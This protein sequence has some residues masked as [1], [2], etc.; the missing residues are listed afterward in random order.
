MESREFY[1]SLSSIGNGISWSLNNDN[2]LTGVGRLGVN[3]GVALNPITALATKRGLGSFGSNKRDT[4]K[5]GKALGLSSE[6]INHV[7]GAI[8]G[9]TNRGNT[10]VVRGKI[11]S[12][13]GV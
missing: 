12:A 9:V 5:A 11:R 6:F 8:N 1:R 13:L 4:V 2:V 3:K 7:Y 10:Q